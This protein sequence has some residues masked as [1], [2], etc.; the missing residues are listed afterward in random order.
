MERERAEMMS[1]TDPIVRR[2]SMNI[3][4]AGDW[5]NGP[6]DPYTPPEQMRRFY[7]AFNSGN[8]TIYG[9]ARVPPTWTKRRIAEQGLFRFSEDLMLAWDIRSLRHIAEE[10]PNA[11]QDK[12]ESK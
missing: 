3:P 7:F 12:G 8:M 1:E 6:E 9:T 5:G 10:T 11:C 2:L 4:D